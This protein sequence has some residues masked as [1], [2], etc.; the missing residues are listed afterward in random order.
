MSERGRTFERVAGD[1]ERHRP[2]YPEAA[3]AWLAERLGLGP[4]RRVLDLAAG[5]GK[6]TRSLVALGAEVVAVEPGAPMLEQLRAAL[7]EV[8]ALEGAAEAIPLPDASVDAVTVAQAFHWFRPDEALAEIHRVLRRGGGLG[9]V[10]NWWD[11]RDPM[12]ARIVELTR[13][14]ASD[15]TRETDPAESGLFTELEDVELFYDVDTTPDDLIARLRTT[16]QILAATPERREAILDEVRAL[17]EERGRRFALAQTTHA[18]VC[19]RRG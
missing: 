10:W 6:F 14:A 2:G 12:Q 9:L 17:A 19:F 5:T 8:E 4:G 13:A 3:V 16:S 18:H 15:E 7:P 1:Y 11:E